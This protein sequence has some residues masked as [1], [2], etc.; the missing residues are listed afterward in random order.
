MDSWRVTGPLHGRKFN[1]KK[2]Y[3]NKAPEKGKSY[4]TTTTE[5][6]EDT[7]HIEGNDKHIVMTQSQHNNLID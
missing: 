1:T 7:K 3:E 2:E 4:H 6:K 5:E